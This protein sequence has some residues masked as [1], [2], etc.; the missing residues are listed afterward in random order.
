MAARQVIGRARELMPTEARDWV[1]HGARTVR[2][3]GKAVQADYGGE[4]KDRE[5]GSGRAGRDAEGRRR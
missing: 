1:V 3:C 5:D 4:H 2:A